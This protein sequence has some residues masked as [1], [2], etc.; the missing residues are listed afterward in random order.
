[1][2]GLAARPLPAWSVAPGP[3]LVAL[4]T[5]QDGGLPQ[6]GCECARCAA[7]RSDPALRRHVA[8]LGIWLPANGRFY[9]V[10]A[11]PDL[12]EQIELVHRVRGL[13]A[14]LA[15]QGLTDRR[16]VDGVLLTHAHIGHSLGLAFFGFEALDTRALP[17][18]GSARMMAFLAANAPWDQLVR[19]GNIVP[20]ALAPGEP[21]ALGDGVTAVPLAVPHRAE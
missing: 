16:P 2:A 1:L 6:P 7:A 3:L 12:G 11:T 4:G 15:A 5:A 14:G 21:L 17:V 13:A 18:Y 9:L 10:D 19:R 8:S 20:H